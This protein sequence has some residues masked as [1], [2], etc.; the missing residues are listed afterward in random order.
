MTN[1]YLTIY[2][3][4]VEQIKSGEILPQTL[5]PSENELKDQFD[6]SRETIR[7]ALNLLSQNGYIQKV[8]G[9]GSIVIDIS[10]FDF[11]VS[12]LVSFKE[13]AKKMGSKPKTIVNEL[14]LIKPD[15]FI[16]K[17]L[18]LS[19]KD[20][21]WKVIRTREMGGEKII[22]DKDF[23]YKKYVPNLTEEICADSIY[24]YLENEL[25][26]TISFAKKEIVVEE[27]TEED[28]TLL[29]LE[30][31]HNVVVIKNYVYLDDATLF[32]YTESRHRPDKFRFVDFARRT[33]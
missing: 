3:N 20:I 7:K 21:V 15:V 25:N 23:L 33:R 11:P 26:L 17:Q 8:R 12:G 30:G 14:E 10:K 29:D 1:K 19:S 24:Q 5:L 6:T 13:L 16:R 9:K 31:F 28:R 18:Q 4:I 32:Q 22:L 27:P 2:N